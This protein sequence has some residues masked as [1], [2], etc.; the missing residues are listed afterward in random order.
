MLGRGLRDFASGVG[1]WILGLFRCK[2]V[3]GL[4][5]CLGFAFYI[6]PIPLVCPAESLQSFARAPIPISTKKCSSTSSDKK[7][8]HDS[9][10]ALSHPVWDMGMF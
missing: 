10:S 2:G 8:T 7:P 4:R 3:A 6:K 9:C 5:H 1:V